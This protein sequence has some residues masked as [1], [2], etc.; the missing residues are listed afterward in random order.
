MNVRRHTWKAPRG[1][2]FTLLETLMCLAIL[3]ALVALSAPSFQAMLTKQRISAARTELVA[4]IQWARWEALRRNTR[5]ALL[6]RTDCSAQLVSED[7]W[8]CGW[9][10]VAGDAITRNSVIPPADI[11]QTFSVPAGVR[12]LHQGGG[13]SLQIARSGYPL[14]VANKFVIGKPAPG[15]TGV[16]SE[17]H[18]ATLC[19]NRTGRV[20]AIEGQTTC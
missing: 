3:A 15:T 11:L 17:R 8:D 4:A 10:I 18:V 2:G 9:I 6:R 19:M 1:T 16:A 14:L 20:R 5:V 7:Q 12:V 13:S